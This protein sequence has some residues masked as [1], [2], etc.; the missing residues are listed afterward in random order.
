MA[1]QNGNKI[2]PNEW[3]LC[4]V[5]CKAFQRSWSD[6][7]LPIHSCL[8]IWKVKRFSTLF[9]TSFNSFLFSWSNHRFG[10]SFHFLFSIMPPRHR[11]VALMGYRSVGKY[12]Q[13]V[14]EQQMQL[15]HPTQENPVWLFST[16]KN[17]GQITMIQLLKTVSIKFLSILNQFVL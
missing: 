10:P 9:S 17:G 12:W 11:K 7:P 6:A 5:V 4:V 15:F 8:R 16:L 14:S 1:I 3:L 2:D 13:H